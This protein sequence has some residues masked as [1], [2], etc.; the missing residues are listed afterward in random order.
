MRGFLWR[1]F[2]GATKTNNPYDRLLRCEN[3]TL[4]LAI[5]AHP[6]EK[7]TDQAPHLEL[8]FFA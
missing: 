5:A 1:L 4:V 7:I 6:R 2:D 8:L 3:A